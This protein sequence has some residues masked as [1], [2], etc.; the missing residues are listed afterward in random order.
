MTQSISLIT[1]IV[2]G[3]FVVGILI[4]MVGDKMGKVSDAVGTNTK[5][6]EDSLD[7]KTECSACCAAGYG[8]T[9]CARQFVACDCS[10]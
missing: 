8:E 3:L 1:V 2:V 7:C 6:A 10:C 5:I 9:V 4:L